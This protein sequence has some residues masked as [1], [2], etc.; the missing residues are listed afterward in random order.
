MKSYLDCWIGA[1]TAL[2]S[3]ALAAERFWSRRWL[4]REWTSGPDGANCCA[5]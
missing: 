3:Q 4:A 2:F 1:A 5:R